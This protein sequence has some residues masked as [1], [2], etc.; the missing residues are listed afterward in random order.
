MG[1]LNAKVGNTA[2]KN[3]TGR[4]GLGNRNEAGDRLVE[5]CIE[6]QLVI[7]NTLFEQH[8]RRLYTWTSPGGGYKNQIDYI[9]CKRR[10]KSSIL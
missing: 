10:W 4:F 9:L 1:D 2:Q 3:V 5:F 7:T 8:K 6:N